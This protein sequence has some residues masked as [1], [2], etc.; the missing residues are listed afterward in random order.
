MSFLNKTEKY[1][2]NIHNKILSISN[3]L[4]DSKVKEK[5]KALEIILGL[6]YNQITKGES[7]P[8][9]DEDSDEKEIKRFETELSNLGL[10]EENKESVGIDNSKMDLMSKNGDSYSPHLSSK[11]IS[12]LNK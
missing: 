3:A 10:L 2:D 11:S 7:S 6:D 9:S 12:K 5:K 4:E 8:Q 1:P